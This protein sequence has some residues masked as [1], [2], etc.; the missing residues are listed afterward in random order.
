MWESPS[1]VITLSVTSLA[2]S[3]TIGHHRQYISIHDQLV[4]IFIYHLIFSVCLTIQSAVFII[5]YFISRIL[6]FLFTFYW[7]SHHILYNFC[8]TLMLKLISMYRSMTL[9]PL[10]LHFLDNYDLKFSNFSR[11]MSSWTE[12]WYAFLNFILDQ[13]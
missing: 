7:N 1:L 12:F 2:N 6:S 4:P 13:K 5:S 3:G 11:F 8:L 10:S 9:P